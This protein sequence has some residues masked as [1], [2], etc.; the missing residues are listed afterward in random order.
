MYVVWTNEINFFD[1]AFKKT[2][3]FL[4]VEAGV[5]PEARVEQANILAGYITEAQGLRKRSAA[6][7]LPVKDHNEWVEKVSEYLRSNLGAAY[8]VRFSDFCGM[9]FLGNSSERSQFEKSIDGRT[10]RLHEFISEIS[11]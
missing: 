10:R 3:G 9:V 7:P 4:G 11:Q 5:T 2:K 1:L 8:E 6:T